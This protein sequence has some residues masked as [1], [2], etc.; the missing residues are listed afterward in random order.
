MASRDPSLAERAAS[1]NY[2]LFVF[3]LDETIWT[4]SE[5]LCSLVRAARACCERGAAK[6]MAA[7]THGLFNGNADVILADSELE[8]IVVAD[9]VPPFRLEQGSAAQKTTALGCAPL[10]AQTIRRLHEGGSVTE[11]TA[12]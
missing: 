2:K 6:V 4:V 1:M 12:F 10:F 9:T 7:A 11:L 3:D 8:Q 5:G